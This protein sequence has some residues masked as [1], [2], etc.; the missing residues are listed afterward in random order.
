MSKQIQLIGLAFLLTIFGTVWGYVLAEMYM[1]IQLLMSEMG[2]VLDIAG[3]L[4]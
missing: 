1:G 2:F 3:G 4:L